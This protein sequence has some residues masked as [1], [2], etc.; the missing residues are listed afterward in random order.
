MISRLDIQVEGTEHV[1]GKWEDGSSKK[2]VGV[3][4][5]VGEDGW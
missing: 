3:G 4:R 2:W 5:G 1:D